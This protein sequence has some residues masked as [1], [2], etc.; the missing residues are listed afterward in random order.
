MY[1]N[2]IRTFV[3]NGRIRIR[4]RFFSRRSDPNPFFSRISDPDPGKPYPDPQ[5]WLLGVCA[6]PVGQ[7][8]GVGGAGERRGRGVPHALAR[9]P[10]HLPPG[11]L[12]DPD[13]RGR[14]I[15]FEKGRI[16]ILFL[17]EARGRIRP[18]HSTPDHLLQKNSYDIK[19][20]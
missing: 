5:P 6:E 15:L 14:R 8:R 1:Q 7:R 19:R 13:Q 10:L 11:R 20:H 16:R 18:K 17:L 9:L 12:A 3:H 2:V 4:I